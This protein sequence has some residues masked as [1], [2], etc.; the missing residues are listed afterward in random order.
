MNVTNALTDAAVTNESLEQISDLARLKMTLEAEIQDDEDT[1]KTKKDRLRIID[2][3]LL[4]EAMKSV[5]LSEFRL[6]DENKTRLILGRF[7]S[8]SLPKMEEPIMRNQAFR[9]LIDNGHG[10][11]IKTDITMAFARG[12]EAAVKKV[13][14][15]LKKT[16]LPFIVKDDVHHTTLRAFIREQYEAGKTVPTGLFNI[17]IG[18]IV[19]IK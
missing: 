15:L 13:T 18:D 14:V 2:Q 19:K 5:G 10:G 1:L 6:D 7:Y 12:E 11:L 4:P 17:Y 8:G 3:E 9:W 16:K